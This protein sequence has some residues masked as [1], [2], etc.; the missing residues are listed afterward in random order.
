MKKIRLCGVDVSSKE[1]VVAVDPGTGCVWK[2]VFANNAAGHRKLIRR[3]SYVVDPETSDVV[4]DDSIGDRAFVR[5]A[6]K[7]VRRWLRHRPN[8]IASPLA[9]ILVRLAPSWS[10]QAADCLGR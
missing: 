5:E 7:S 9:L 3:L 4:V 6:E 8:E 1:L 2:G 10:G